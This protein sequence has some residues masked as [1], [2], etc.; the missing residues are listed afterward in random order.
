MMHAG[1]AETNFSHFSSPLCR[2]NVQQSARRRCRGKN[3]ENEV[4][5]NVWAFVLRYVIYYIIIYFIVL[6]QNHFWYQL[7]KNVEVQH[8][9]HP[10]AGEMRNY[11]NLTSFPIKINLTSTPYC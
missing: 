5:S 8:L 3:A 11:L 7:R 1:K 4:Q 9:T 2:V 6:H 10:C